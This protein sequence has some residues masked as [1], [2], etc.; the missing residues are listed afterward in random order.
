ME[1][2]HT[3]G[4]WTVEIQDS[5]ENLEAI[6]SVY[7]LSKPFEWGNLNPVEKNLLLVQGAAEGKKFGEIIND[8]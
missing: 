5:I 3:Q 4:E 7:G 2:K 6:P 1:S 8:K